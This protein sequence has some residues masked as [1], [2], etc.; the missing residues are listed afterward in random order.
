MEAA[1]A[2][3]VTAA[4]SSSLTAMLEEAERLLGSDPQEAHRVA[5]A[6]HRL[7]RESGLVREIAL[8]DRM[9]GHCKKALEQHEQAVAVAS[10]LMEEHPSSWLPF[11]A[12]T[13]SLI[14]LGQQAEAIELARQRLQQREGDV[15]GMRMLASALQMNGQL[16]S[17]SELWN[18]VVAT[19]EALA[20]DFNNRAWLSLFVDTVDDRAM[21]WANAAVKRAQ[22][23]GVPGGDSAALHT[24]A[25]LYAERGMPAE[26]YQV[27]VQSMDETKEPQ[28]ADWYVFG[29]MAET[30]GFKEAA[31]SAYQ[32]AMD[33]EED[34]AIST[35][36]LARK[37]LAHFSRKD[38]ARK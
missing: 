21:R 33:D 36:V 9:R 14:E 28:P 19:S 29:R 16:E 37:R 23:S 7:A 17:A 3:V 32:R 26:A 5:D 2:A 30:Y 8:A 34:H 38:S 18:K 12:M 15:F 24:L 6:A 1:G 4:R 27:I 10:Q 35:A 22:G 11:T 13:S 25:T 20:M 31:R